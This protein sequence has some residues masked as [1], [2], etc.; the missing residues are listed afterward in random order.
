M[1]CLYANLYNFVLAGE[2]APPTSSGT[3]TIYVCKILTFF[4]SLLQPH[5][6]P[7]V[8]GV[9]SGNGV[10]L[11]TPRSR[12]L[13][14]DRLSAQSASDNSHSAGR[15]VVATTSQ[16]PF[17]AFCRPSPA[18]AAGSQNAARSSKVAALPL[19]TTKSRGVRI[20]ATNK[21]EATLQRLLSI[22]PVKNRCQCYK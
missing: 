2:C 16:K 14:D 15:K 22:V 18:A 5:E 10:K 8:G 17:T 4:L 1:P 19:S 12:S 20:I 11:S 13:S 21:L 6:V 3:P 9:G 7:V